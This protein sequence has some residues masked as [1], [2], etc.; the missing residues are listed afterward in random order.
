M[1]KDHIF[2]KQCLDEHFGDNTLANCSLCRENVNKLKCRAIKCM[3]RLIKRLR[4]KC[5]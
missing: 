4:V 1:I 2:C 3:D 5:K